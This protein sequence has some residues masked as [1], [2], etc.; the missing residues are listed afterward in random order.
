[1]LRNLRRLLTVLSLV[2]LP[3]GRNLV[4]IRKPPALY[5]IRMTAYTLNG[6]P[7]IL[8]LICAHLRLSQLPERTFRLDKL[9]CDEISRCWLF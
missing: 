7:V 3:V 5:V 6:V 1:V 9:R 8:A 4:D 2:F